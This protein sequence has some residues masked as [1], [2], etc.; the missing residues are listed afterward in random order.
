MNKTWAILI[1]VAEYDDKS[2]N[3]SFVHGDNDCIRQGLEKGL[4]IPSEQIVVCGNNCA[5]E[6]ADFK[7]IISL[8]SGKI[9]QSDRVIVY[10]SGHGGGAPFS[11]KFTDVCKDFS[12]VCAEIDRLPACAK[13]LIIDAC[14][15]GNG[16]IPELSTT[17]PSHNL[18]DYARSGYAVFASSNAGSTSTRHPEKTVSLYTYCFSNA[19]CHAKIRNG[20]VSLIDVAKQAALEADYISRTH[21]ITLQHPVFKCH[22]PGDVLFQ[23]AE[24]RVI[25]NNIYSSCRA[26]YDVYSTEILHSSIE[27]R[28][29]VF[30]I[31]KSDISDELIAS[32]TIQ[33]AEE[34]RPLRKFKTMQQA[35]RFYGK[36]TAVVFVYWGKSEEDIIRR[37][38][39]YM[40]RWAAPSSN[41]ANWYRVDKDSKIV[42]DIWVKSIHQYSLLAELYE[43]DTV[44]NTELIQLTHDIADPLLVAAH[45]V[46]RYFEEYD[47]GEIPE[48]AFIQACT[49]QFIIIQSC[50]WR[51]ANLPIPS[52]ELKEWADRYDCLTAS[53]DDMRIFY[54]TKTFLDREESNRKAC[55]RGTVSKY[56]EDLQRLIHMEEC[57]KKSGIIHTDTQ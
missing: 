20:K 12:E 22:I 50:Y 54:T 46:V 19:L 17:N 33:I 44:S 41:R 55:M 7:D 14:H 34:I 51:M 2:Y 3:L 13:I 31:A 16:E 29:S 47:N 5:V 15:S 11:L 8:Y 25:R 32:Y 10:F 30:A 21:G 35:M 42:S 43:R 48:Y 39:I 36:S 52:V 38:W 6:Y 56:R 49:E 9:A 28:Y 27:M 37:N 23:I 26:H 53:I 1:S 18:F 4:L 57:L 24:E 40:S 45:E